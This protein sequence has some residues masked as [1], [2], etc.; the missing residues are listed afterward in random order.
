M[1]VL[2]TP[3]GTVVQYGGSSD[4]RSQSP[5]RWAVAARRASSS[6][7][8][9]LPPPLLSSDEAVA[10]ASVSLE[11]DGVG[12]IGVVRTAAPRPARQAAAGGRSGAD[13]GS[14]RFQPRIGTAVHFD[15]QR[16]VPLERGGAAHARVREALLYGADCD[17]R[18]VVT[19]ERSLAALRLH[20][21]GEVLGRARPRRHRQ[22]V[23]RV[24]PTLELLHAR[25]PAEQ[26]AA[27]GSCETRRMRSLSCS[28]ET[29]RNA[30]LPCSIS[31]STAPSAH[32]ST[33]MPR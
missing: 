3:G 14:L 16:T 25:A 7:E 17:L 2:I 9:V 27:K 15:L 28:I 1:P 10:G 33:G 13:D 31:Y 32:M 19:A 26:P 23:R 12:P 6:I 20:A 4:S 24:E 29:P 5:S 8:S 30:G 22:L 21:A 18:A 11:L